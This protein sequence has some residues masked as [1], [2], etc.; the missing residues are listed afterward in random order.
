MK[1]NLIKSGL[2]GAFALALTAAAALA[3]PGAA[4]MQQSSATDAQLVQ[5]R[6]E[7]RGGGGGSHGGGS[8]HGGGGFHG[9]GSH[10][11]HGGIRN[12][13]DF[14]VGPSYYGDDYYGYDN[15]R[16]SLRYHRE[17]CY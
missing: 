12:G 10:S 13:F 7:F 15:C 2:V 17:I 3:Q 4:T 16:W 6:G 11:H 9:G 8:F 14:F 5:V 1:R